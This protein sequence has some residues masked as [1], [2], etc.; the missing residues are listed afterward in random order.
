MYG[1][2][3][4]MT[5]KTSRFIRAGEELTIDYGPE[6]FDEDFPCQCDAFTYPHTSEVYRRRVHPD[7]TLSPTGIGTYGEAK[8][9]RGGGDQAG[10]AG[11]GGSSV[12]E[13]WTRKTRAG[14]AKV[15][16]TQ[17][18]RTRVEKTRVEKPRVT[19]MRIPKIV[20]ST[21][22][23]ASAPKVSRRRSWGSR[24]YKGGDPDRNPLRR[25]ARIAAIG[26]RA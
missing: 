12:A 18:G 26:L 9:K 21:T 8:G 2:R 16:K 1:R 24:A 14:Q 23:K 3:A 13:T 19:R 7:G 22:K 17:V 15:K 10:G 4:V 6:Y 11:A 5:F 20:L 25:S